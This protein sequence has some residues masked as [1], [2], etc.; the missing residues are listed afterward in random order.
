MTP[1][2]KARQKIDE[3][4]QQCGWIIQDF[5]E[6]NL[7]AARGVAIREVPLKSG[8]CDYLLVADRNAVGVIE[9]KKEGTL[10]SGVAEH[11]RRRKHLL[12]LAQTWYSTRS[13]TRTSVAW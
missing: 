1:E 10:F 11:S 12:G 6:L 5:K 7:S 8:T 2:E 13:G 9:A 4:L 3:L